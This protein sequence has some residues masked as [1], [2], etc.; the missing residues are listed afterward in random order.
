MQTLIWLV[1]ATSGNAA[2]PSVRLSNGV[3]M[4]VLAFAAWTWDRSTCHD[5]TALALKAGFRFIWSSTLVGA[6]CQQSQATAIDQ[7]GISRSELFL[8]GTVNTQS[9]PD[10]ATCF[11][12]TMDGA[13]DQFRVINA[14]HLDMLM[15]DYPAS[16]GCSAITG[17]WQALEALYSAGRVGTIAVSNFSPEQLKCILSNTSA[18]VPTVNQMPYFVGHGK[19]SVVAVDG[20]YDIRVQAYSPLGRGDLARDPELIKIGKAYNKSA[21]QVALR[22]IVQRNVTIATQSTSLKHLQEDCDIFDFELSHED[23]QQLNAHA[24]NS[25][26]VFL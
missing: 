7:S 9:C 3:D 5:A 17:Q 13:E 10:S 8:A 21:A 19:D 24:T 4:P 20:K 12:Q 6:E 22:W 14:H 25:R 11:K 23:M 18:A 15:L 26:P 2:V 16:A 1:L